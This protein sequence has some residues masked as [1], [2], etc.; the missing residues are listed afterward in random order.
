MLLTPEPLARSLQNHP[1]LLPD[2]RRYRRHSVDLRGRYMRANKRELTCAVIDISPGGVAIA[3]T[4]AVDLGERIIA[5]FDHLGTLEGQVV[6][7]VDGG[8][9]MPIIASRTRREKLAAQI[10]WLINRDVLSPQEVRQHDRAPVNKPMT[11]KL[12]DDMVVNVK[13]IDVSVSG[14]SIGTEHRPM[15]GQEVMVGRLRARVVRHHTEGIAVQ[16]I[17]IQQTDTMRRS[18]G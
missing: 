12:P 14:A 2:R 18:F 1:L 3:T 9:A 7:L 10:T 11:L 17:D 6:R 4:E 8:F 5:Y 13:V 16:F 15:L